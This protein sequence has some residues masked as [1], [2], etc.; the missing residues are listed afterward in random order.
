MT[1][2]LDSDWP[3][4]VGHQEPLH[5]LAD[6]GDPAEAEKACTLA[7]R[8][9]RDQLPWQRDTLHGI[10]ALNDD[11][12]F[13]HPTAIVIACR[14]NGKTLSAAELRIIYGAFNRHETVVYS[15]Q[16]WLTAKSIYL[17]VKRLIASR[18]SLKRRA[19][20]WLCSQGVAGFTVHHDDGTESPVMF[21]TRSGD[22]RGPD[23]I[24]LVIYDEAYNLT[25]AAM[26]AIGPTQ[27]AAKNPQTIYLSSAVNEDIHPNGEVLARLRYRALEA[28]R[29]DRTGTGVYYAEYA[30]PE[31]DPALSDVERRALRENPETWRL[32]NPSM[33]VIHSDA[34]VQKL[35]SEL[36]AT[37][38]EVE[39]LGW[40]RWPRTEEGAASII[41]AST[42][43]DMHN[44]NAR[45]QLTGSC[46]L[47]AH[48][49]RNRQVWSIA[50]AQ[51]TADGRIH[52][53]IG[54][55]RSG[56]HAQ[57]AEY[58]IAKVAEWNPV[59]LVIDRK[60]QA[61]VLQPLLMAAGIE[62][63]MTGAP[64]AAAS[65]EVFLNDALDG[66]LSHSDQQML[67]DA[68]ISASFREL[69]GGDAAWAEDIEGVAGPLIAASQAVWA[70]RKFGSKP[71]R[72]TVGARTAAKRRPSP[73][74][75]RRRSSSGFDPMTTSF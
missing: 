35:L 59:A 70:L 73:E 17:R 21:I 19:S 65:C 57:V 44:P 51:M 58:L 43:N 32:A 37:S 34:K 22:F 53:E 42:W 25:D 24:D 56:S 49:S 30:A 61:S 13:T 2:L 52:P 8:V 55:M 67:N 74:T 31:P 6:V 27:L 50:A 7:A 48:R 9:K 54:P 18:P 4:L 75:A 23:E 16:R 38:F 72:K 11:G 60:N 14:Q 15:A 47:A 20:G 29:L 41:P 45:D 26:A 12:L 28:I 3:T 63:V 66:R 62:P 40:G 64:E 71:K 33:G 5:L 36:S 39:V 10:L 69:P 1:T 68:V 46:T